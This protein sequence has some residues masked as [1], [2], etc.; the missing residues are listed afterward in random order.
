MK[1]KEIMQEINTKVYLKKKEIK[2]EKMVRIDIKICLRKKKQKLKEYQKIIGKLKYLTL[3]INIFC[4]FSN[5]CY[6]LVMD[7]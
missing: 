1:E 6:S 7:C 5:V 2:R 4:G 3:V